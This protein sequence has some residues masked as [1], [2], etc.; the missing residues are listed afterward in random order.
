MRERLTLRSWLAMAQLESARD[1]PAADEACVW[2]SSMGATVVSDLRAAIQQ[3]RETWVTEADFA[4][5]AAFGMNAVRL[6]IGC[7]SC[8]CLQSKANA[9]PWHRVTQHGHALISK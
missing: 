5:V 6:P 4:M 3:H 7:E 1:E 8:S 9:L 2:C